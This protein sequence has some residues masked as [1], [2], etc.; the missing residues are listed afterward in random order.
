MC[1]WTLPACS[2]DRMLLVA[3]CLLTVC[4]ADSLSIRHHVCRVYLI[5]QYVGDL[6]GAIIRFCRLPGEPVFVDAP[7]DCLVIAAPKRMDNS[8]FFYMKHT[9]W[10]YTMLLPDA[11]APSVQMARRRKCRYY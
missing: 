8:Q 6:A 9:L 3:S 1:L 4:A 11:V 2:E 5:G 10:S 7:C